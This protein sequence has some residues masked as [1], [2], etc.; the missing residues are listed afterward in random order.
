MRFFA[1]V[2][3]I[4]LFS[5]F[6]AG[7]SLSSEKATVTENVVKGEQEKV[8]KEEALIKEKYPNAIRTSSGLMY[9]ILK[10]GNGATPTS[11]ALVEAHYTGRLLDG[12]KFDSSVERGK[13][14]LFLVGRGEVI[15]GWDEAFLAMK[16]GE[17]RILIIPPGLAYGDKG[18]GTIPPNETLIFEVELICFLR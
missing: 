5:F 13:P 4:T 15:K 7:E 16:K 17:K 14:L 18:M 8:A 9:I 11:G 12:T 2:S 3:L 1:C 6:I 10:E